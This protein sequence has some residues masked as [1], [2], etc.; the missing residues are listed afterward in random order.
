MPRPSLDQKV[1]ESR[2]APIRSGN[3]CC[4][5]TRDLSL[6]QVHTTD[7]LILAV[8]R[9]G[10]RDEAGWRQN[11]SFGPAVKA[12]DLGQ[13]AVHRAGAVALIDHGNTCACQ[14]VGVDG[15]GTLVTEQIDPFAQNELTPIQV[16]GNVG[17]NQF[18]KVGT[19]RGVGGAR[20]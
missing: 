4:E 14:V 11:A 15:L 9:E 8:L 6:G 7:K 20:K 13:V 5:Q 12:A 1:D 19:G 17:V 18:V 3:G 10:R 2:E 16:G